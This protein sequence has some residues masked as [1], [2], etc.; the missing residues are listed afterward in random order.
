MQIQ[1]EVFLNNKRVISSFLDKGSPLYEGFYFDLQNKRV[2]FQS[3]KGMGF[4][5]IS[6]EGDIGPRKNFLVSASKFLDLVSD[7]KELTLT[8]NYTFV[9]GR[10]VNDFGH[11][12]NE[13][14]DELYSDQNFDFSEDSELCFNAID[15]EQFGN[16]LK[17]VD[18]FDPTAKG[19]FLQDGYVFS[20][21]SATPA[22]E[23]KVSFAGEVAFT[24][25]AAHLMIDLGSQA[26]VFSRRN[27]QNF[28]ISNQDLTFLLTGSSK[29]Q[30]P[31]FRSKEFI[32]SYQHSSKVTLNYQEFLDSLTSLSKFFSDVVNARVQIS[33]GE[34]FSLTLSEPI[35]SLHIS[36]PV[37][38]FVLDSAL[39]N[40]TFFISGSKLLDSLKQFKSCEE[41]SLSVDLEK[42][43]IDIS[44]TD[45]E[46]KHIVVARMRGD[47]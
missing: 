22:F 37:N 9:S 4:L 15:Y 14:Y 23:G 1:T 7:F 47:I 46:S 21:S 8:E 28:L 33:L 45:E 40:T 44:S 18:K 32:D 3:S 11:L 42:N 39:N 12:I 2:Y 34:E 38:T 31:P 19:L 13:D 30:A 36:R 10:S 35:R 6:I 5:N 41:I 27:G 16:A 17:F 20:Y 29:L 26:K 24:E 25:A 43:V